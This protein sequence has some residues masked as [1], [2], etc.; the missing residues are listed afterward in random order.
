M[1][2]N[3]RLHCPHVKEEDF[4]HLYH[5]IDRYRYHF[6]GDELYVGRAVRQFFK[7]EFNLQGT[8]TPPLLISPYSKKTGSPNESRFLDLHKIMYSANGKNKGGP[9]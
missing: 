5:C 1:N 9:F 4:L 7:V 2:G 3:R 8:T 6:W